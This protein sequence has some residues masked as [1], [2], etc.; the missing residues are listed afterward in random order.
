[1]TLLDLQI[2][3]YSRNRP[4]I[5]PSPLIVQQNTS[6]LRAVNEIESRSRSEYSNI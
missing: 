1:M 6:S 3:N 5:S 4:T 2:L